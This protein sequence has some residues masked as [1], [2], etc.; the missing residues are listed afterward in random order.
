MDIFTFLEQLASNNN[1]TWFHAHKEE[2]EE[3]RQRWYDDLQ[4]LICAMSA[5]E[6]ALSPLSPKE[7]AFR[8]YRDVRFSS[9]KSPYKTYF[10]AI[11][12][13]N[14][15]HA[16]CAAYY[17]Q[18]DLRSEE[19]GLYG[20]LWCPDQ[21]MLRK[22]RHAIVDNIEEFD[23]IINAPELEEHFP[24]WV[25]NAL[26]TIP[27]G[28]PKDHPQAGLLR[29][30]DYGK[31]CPCTRGFFSVPDWPEK[32]ASLFSMLKPMIDFINYSL[33]EEL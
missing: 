14:G 16:Q 1:R 9:D 12:N 19:S 17:L 32:A 6:P 30:K 2:Y 4:R 25:G 15:R 33:Y 31:F 3:V 26:K 24:G 18:I 5:W 20:G 7:A 10:S 13:P 8:I 28:W 23:G 22:M 11:F 29:L 27:Q 21:S